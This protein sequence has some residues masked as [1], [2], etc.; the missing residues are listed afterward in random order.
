VEARHETSRHLLT[1]ISKK[2]S[3]RGLEGEPH[4]HGLAHG[5]GHVALLPRPGD[6]LERDPLCRGDPRRPAAVAAVKQAR[7]PLSPVPLARL[8]SRIARPIIL[9]SSGNFDGPK[10]ISASTMMRSISWKPT[11]NMWN[12]I[13]SPGFAVFQRNAGGARYPGGRLRI[14][15]GRQQPGRAPV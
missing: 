13:L 4:L 3:L 7:P 2:F 15:P 6:R 5:T 9:P 14:P 8:N 11:S 12:H 10:T 1:L